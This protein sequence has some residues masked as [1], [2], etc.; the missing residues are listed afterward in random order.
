[1]FWSEHVHQNAA[2]DRDL[3]LI[4]RVEALPAF[5][6]DDDQ[7]SFFQ[8][9]QMVADGRLIHFPA[10]FVHDIIHAEP[11]AAQVSHNLLARFVGKRFREQHWINIHNSHYIDIYQYVKRSSL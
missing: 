3:L 2:A 9:F 1:M 8:L 7:I 10:E 11:H 6:A 5:L 4:Q